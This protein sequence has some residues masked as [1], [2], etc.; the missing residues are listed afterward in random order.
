MLE[1]LKLAKYFFKWEE[2]YSINDACNNQL[3][4]AKLK[5]RQLSSEFSLFKQKN[6][7]YEALNLLNLLRIRKG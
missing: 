4:S 6:L 3:S 5:Y 1:S 2:F 7:V